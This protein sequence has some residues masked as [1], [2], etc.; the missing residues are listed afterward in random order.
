[1]IP[2]SPPMDH[3]QWHSARIQTS[4]EATGTG[5]V[6][7]PVTAPKRVDSLPSF[8]ARLD[9]VSSNA[10]RSRHKP[11]SRCVLRCPAGPLTLAMRSD[12]LSSGPL[13]APRRSPPG[14][15]GSCRALTGHRADQGLAHCLW[16]YSLGRPYGRREAG[17]GTGVSPAF[18]AA[19]RLTGHQTGPSWCERVE[20]PKKPS[21]TSARRFSASHCGDRQSRGACM[22]KMRPPLPSTQGDRDPLGKEKWPPS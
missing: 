19:C 11:F 14:R 12:L 2:T 22:R 18:V 9:S 16:R 17:L 3:L 15:S 7:R 20:C 10:S 1:M 6:I 13:K 5:I 4:V 8:F 21:A